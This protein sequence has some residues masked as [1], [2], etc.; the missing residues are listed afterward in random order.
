M[1]DRFPELKSIPSG[2]PP[3]DGFLDGL[4]F[5]GHVCGLIYLAVFLALALLLTGLPYAAWLLTRT[6]LLVT[7]G[8]TIVWAVLVPGS[9]W[10]MLLPTLAPALI[11]AFLVSRY[12]AAP[13]RNA[14]KFYPSD[15]P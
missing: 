2:T 13:N 11:L 9:L 10:T 4:F 3:N 15:T 5:L 8:A 12:A 14:K 7:V 6:I 1:M